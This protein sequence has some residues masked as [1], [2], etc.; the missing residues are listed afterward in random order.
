[1]KC[2]SEEGSMKAKFGFTCRRSISKRESEL[3]KKSMYEKAGLRFKTVYMSKKPIRNVRGKEQHIHKM[4]EHFEME[5]YE[6]DVSPTEV[7]NHTDKE[8]MDFIKAIDPTTGE[9]GEWVRI[10]RRIIEEEEE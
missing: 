9:Y 6:N 1:M 2:E 7:Y 3:N 4:M 5:R 10:G 8:V